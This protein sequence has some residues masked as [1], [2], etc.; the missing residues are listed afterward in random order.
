MPRQASDHPLSASGRPRPPSDLGPLLRLSLSEALG[1]ALAALPALAGL[2]ALAGLVALAL[3]V[4]G[5]LAEE[6]PGP[7]PLEGAFEVAN[8]TR[9]MECKGEVEGEVEVASAP[10]TSPVWF[11]GRAP[12]RRVDGLS[13]CDFRFGPLEGEAEGETAA[14]ILPGQVC[15]E[16][17]VDSEGQVIPRQIL[18]LAWSVRRLEEGLLWESYELLLVEGRGERA[19]HC[20]LSAAATLARAGEELERSPKE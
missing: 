3:L 10:F 4:A 18:P 9:R 8:G 7:A 13:S 15:Q 2:A 5:C 16:W 6:Q 20:R 12:L 17:R 14:E 19:R 1:P 11:Y